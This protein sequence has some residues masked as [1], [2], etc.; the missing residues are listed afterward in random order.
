MSDQIQ[1]LSR[2]VH[3]YYAHY[4][5]NA[6]AKI[7]AIFG[8]NFAVA[9]LLIANLPDGCVPKA[10]AWQAVALGA[11]AGGILLYGIYPRTPSPSGKESSPI[12]WE[13]VAAESSADEYA[14][15]VE[16]LS[17]DQIERAYALNNYVVAGVLHTKFWAI[18]IAIWF[19][20]AA[21]VSTLASVI[22]R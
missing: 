20:V 2:A 7:G 12:F 11:V 8:L 16:S 9:G 21:L 19:T 10:F 15:R 3:D 22:A 13:D 6:D 1:G 14:T 17:A 18:R 5:D 4:A